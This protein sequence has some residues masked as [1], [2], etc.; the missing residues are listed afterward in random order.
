MKTTSNAAIAFAIDDNYIR[1]GEVLL[2]TLRSNNINTTVICRSIDMSEQKITRLKDILPELVVIRDNNNLSTAR[3]IF[4]KFDNPTE[5]Y[6]TYNGRINTKE[7]IENIRKTM[8]S[9]RAVYS[10]HSRFKTIVEILPEYDR[11]MCLDADTIV[12]KNI[13]HLFDLDAYCDNDLYIVPIRENKQTKL[14]NNEGLLLINNTTKAKQFF[15]TVHDQIFEGVN[16]QDWDIDT[17]VLTDVYKSTPIDIGH[18]S[19]SYKDKKHIDDSYMWSGDG[20]RKNQ[21]RF[22]SIIDD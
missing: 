5:I 1:Y 14:F 17:K 7:G 18:L 22:K 9:D 4:K 2:E 19:T 6:W 13:N 21:P 12:R 16:Y 20:T 3:N 11:I 8:Y 15:N 10:C